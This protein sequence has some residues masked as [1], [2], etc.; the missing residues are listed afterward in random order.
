MECL[1]HIF[2]KPLDLLRVLKRQT[3]QMILCDGSH[4]AR[5]MRWS[6]SMNV[7]EECQGIA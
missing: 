5:L 1:F 4:D 6:Q 7:E 2:S 3:N